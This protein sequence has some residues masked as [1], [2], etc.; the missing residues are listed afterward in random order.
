MAGEVERSQPEP[1]DAVV[2]FSVAESTDHFGDSKGEGIGT[3]AYHEQVKVKEG[4]HFLYL[5]CTHVTHPS[6]HRP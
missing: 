5:S 1:P 3:K 2:G 6:L 4:P